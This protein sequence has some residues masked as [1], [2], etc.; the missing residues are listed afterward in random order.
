MRVFISRRRHN[1]AHILRVQ[2]HIIFPSAIYFSVS[3]DAV[4]VRT[5]EWSESVAFRSTCRLHSSSSFGVL[6]EAFHLIQE[7]TSEYL[8]DFIIG[9]SRH[10]SSIQLLVLFVFHPPSLNSLFYRSSRNSH[11]E[12]EMRKTNQISNSTLTTAQP[13]TFNIMF[14]YAA[15]S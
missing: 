2:F 8:L 11:V 3:F 15:T 1:T 7:I 10:F 5:T 4:A 13:A 12:Y 14:C 6:D 9:F